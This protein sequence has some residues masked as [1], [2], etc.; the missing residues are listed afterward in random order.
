MFVGNLLK[1][2]VFDEM[3]KKGEGYWVVGEL[4]GIDFVMNNIFWIGVYLGMMKE[5]L[6]YMIIIIKEFCNKWKL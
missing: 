5:M 4:K 3:C 2:L 1:Y 6:D